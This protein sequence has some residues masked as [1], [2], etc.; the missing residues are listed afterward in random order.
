[1]TERTQ[2]RAHERGLARAEV[3]D[4]L[5]LQAVEWFRRGYCSRLADSACEALTERE[6]RG[7]V[8]QFEAAFDERGG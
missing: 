7:F 1:M 4:Q 5:D 8:A 6:R 2:R 3:A